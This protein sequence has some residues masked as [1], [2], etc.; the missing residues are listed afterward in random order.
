MGV[1]GALRG[2][3]RLLPHP[4]A[5]A[6]LEH[7]RCGGAGGCCCRTSSI[8]A[9]PLRPSG[10]G[11]AHGLLCACTR[12]EPSCARCHALPQ[13]S[14]AIKEAA[15]QA[16]A[17]GKAAGKAGGRKRKSAGGNGE[18]AVEEAAV[19]AADVILAKPSPVV[20]AKVGR[21]VGA[22]LWAGQGPSA[23]RGV[24]RVSLTSRP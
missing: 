9:A 12:V 17:E 11:A 19:K 1:L 8:L 15:L 23:E 14:Y 22:L 7:V 10:G 13:V 3:M 18:V 16:A 20:L 5:D 2:H 24:W 4:D 21:W 6:G